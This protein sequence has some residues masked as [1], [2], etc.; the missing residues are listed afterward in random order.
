MSVRDMRNAGWCWQEKATLR[1]LRCHYDGER[2]KQRSTA[3]A[4]Y[5]A[6]TEAASNNYGNSGVFEV[7]HMA[8]ADMTG[9]SRTTIKRYL[10]DFE[11]LGLIAVER[12]KND[13]GTSKPNIYA[14]L[15]PPSTD[16]PYPSMQTEGVQST[17]GPYPPTDGLLL[18]EPTLKKDQEETDTLVTKQIAQRRAALSRLVGKYA[19]DRRYQ[20]F[21]EYDAPPAKV[22]AALEN[23]IF[24]AKKQA[25]R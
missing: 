25:T 11:Q 24:Q 1:V 19:A 9:T 5:L 13:E 3:L 7:V 20:H 8:L 17:D 16:G 22:L 14:L 6:L 4:V 10:S 15:G 23:E 12:R 18:E 2:L 21:R